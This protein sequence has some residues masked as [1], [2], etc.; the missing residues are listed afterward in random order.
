MRHLFDRPL[1]TSVPNGVLLKR[2]DPSA[3]IVAGA[4]LAG[5]I[6]N[7]QINAE[8]SA[9]DMATYLHLTKWNRENQLRDQ[10]WSKQF[11]YD[12]QRQ[13][14][15]YDSPKEQMKRLQEAGLNPYL[16]M[17]GVSGA[18]PNVSKNAMS[19][20]LPGSNSVSPFQRSFLDNPFPSSVSNLVAA[21][22]IKA[23][24][25]SADSQFAKAL[26]DHVTDSH[27]ST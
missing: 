16:A 7:N 27:D 26:P 1:G 19:P 15:L 2:Y 25:I 13:Q 14:N 11:T 8:R 17:Q 22:S 6:A 21:S 5:S 12:L 18:S 20:S 9:S 23:Q 4:Q 3:L 10:E 24:R